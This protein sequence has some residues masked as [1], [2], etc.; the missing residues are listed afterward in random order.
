MA[1]Q[2]NWLKLLNTYTKETESPRDFWLWSGIFCIAAAF[3]RKVWLPF[4][5]EKIYPNLYLMF[6]ADPGWCRKGAP[7]GF[8]RRILKEIKIP[9]GIDSPTKRHLT[10]RLAELTQTE[11]FQYLGKPMSQSAVPLISRELSSFLAVDPKQMI[12]VLTDIY[13][14]HDDWEYGTSTAGEDKIKNLCVS[15]FFA[16]TPGWIVKNLP[17]EAIGGGFTRRFA[18]V[19]GDKRSQSLPI[20]PI[21]DEHLYT[22][23]VEQLHTISLVVGE[24]SWQSEARQIYESWYNTIFQWALDTNDDR[25][26]GTFS[27]IHVIAIK[28]SMCLHIARSPSLIIEEQDINLAIE[29]LKAMMAKAGNAFSSHGRSDLALDT[30][31]VKDQ[32]KIL[33]EISFKKLLRMNYRNLNKTDLWIVLDNLEAMGFVGTKTNTAGQQVITWNNRRI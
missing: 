9:V 4:G 29:L 15:C 32:I 33:R 25:L 27:S 28:I 19:Y 18:I 21:P 17:E 8:A 12:E 31:K 23:L 5:M 7:L 10:K 2:E 1:E 6:V 13:D 11:I 14:S 30:D 22:E 3:Q 20:P 16:T 24:F 26:H